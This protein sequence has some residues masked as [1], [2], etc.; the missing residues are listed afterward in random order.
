L[1]EKK[2][3]KGRKKG[4]E[5]ATPEGGSKNIG[6]EVTPPESRCENDK[7]CPFHGTQSLRG[8]M[9]QGKVIR[10]KVPRSAV[11]EWGWKRKIP[12]YERYEKRRTRVIAHNPSCIGAQEGD[13]VKLMETRKISKTKNFVIISREK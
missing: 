2:S 6:I 4:P 10:S 1:T 13:V 11:V 5:K 3:T 7:H 9:F 12:K 8:R